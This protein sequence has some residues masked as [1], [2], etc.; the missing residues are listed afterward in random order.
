M[1]FRPSPCPLRIW[2][3]LGDVNPVVRVQSWVFS[4]A[5]FC[6]F[7][8]KG[9]ATFWCETLRIPPEA[10]SLLRLPPLLDGRTR[11]R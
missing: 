9:T 8:L 10:G 3:F 4:D 5:G 7:G 2:W 11:M 6:F 1:P